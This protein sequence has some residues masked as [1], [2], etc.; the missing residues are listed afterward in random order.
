MYVVEKLTDRDSRCLGM[1]QRAAASA[2]K[3]YYK[4]HAEL[5]SYRAAKAPAGSP[6]QTPK[7]SP[8]PKLQ[9]EPNSPIAAATAPGAAPIP[10]RA[11]YPANLA[12][13]L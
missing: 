11:S 4:A 6:Q 1:V 3:S 8:R 10:L 9:N 13:R 5:L 12:L 2:E 7:L